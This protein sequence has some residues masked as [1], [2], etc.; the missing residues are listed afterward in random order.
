MSGLQHQVQ[1]SLLRGLTFTNFP[2]VR[3]LWHSSLVSRQWLDSQFS[4]RLYRTTVT[5]LVYWACVVILSFMPA[6]YV[7]EL[8]DRVFIILS[9]MPASYV[10]KFYDRVLSHWVLCPRA[11]LM[12]FTTACLE[13]EW[14]ERVPKIMSQLESAG[15]EL[16]CRSSFNYY[17]IIFMQVITFITL[18]VE[19]FFVKLL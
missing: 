12:S 11:M 10:V 18:D 13:I 15:H 9:F 8:Y 2:E 6:S 17:N 1:C 16:K 19:L 14:V 4:P 3:P 5:I 7:D